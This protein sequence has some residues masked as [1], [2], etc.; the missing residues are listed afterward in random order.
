MNLLFS[1]LAF[2]QENELSKTIASCNVEAGVVKTW[3]NF[4]E[5]TWQLQSSYDEQNE[6][7]AKYVVLFSPCKAI[8]KTGPHFLINPALFFWFMTVVM[9]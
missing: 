2:N 4:L 5:D 3:I 6:K 7:K 9:S 1:S 8:I